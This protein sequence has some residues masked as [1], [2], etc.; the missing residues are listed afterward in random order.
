M[1]LSGEKRANTLDAWATLC[2]QVGTGASGPGPGAAAVSG[3]DLV[4]GHAL[5]SP[6]SDGVTGVATRCELKQVR[7]PI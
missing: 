1:R 4:V 7:L 5:V 2:G 3:G 6:F